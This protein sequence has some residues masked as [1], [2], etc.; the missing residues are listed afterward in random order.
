MRIPGLLKDKVRL[1]TKYYLNL[2]MLTNPGAYQLP[3]AGLAA[4]ADGGDIFSR[5]CSVAL[6]P[7][8]RRGRGGSWVCGGDPVSLA[9]DRGAGSALRWVVPVRLLRWDCSLTESVIFLNFQSSVGP[10]LRL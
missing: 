10:V 5:A 1:V 9:L 6:Q 2:E 8:A 7:P 4:G 3:A